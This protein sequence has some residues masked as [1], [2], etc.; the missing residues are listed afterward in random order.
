M[1][2]MGG[3]CIVG[4]I[5]WLLLAQ[6]Q[7]PDRCGVMGMAPPVCLTGSAIILLPQAR[8]SRP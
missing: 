2:P 4:S 8:L 3:I 6:G 5:L 1:P 7:R